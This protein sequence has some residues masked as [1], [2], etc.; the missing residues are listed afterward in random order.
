M[1]LGFFYKEFLFVSR[2]IL[3]QLVRHMMPFCR[4]I[5]IATD[6]GANMRTMRRERATKRS[7]K[8]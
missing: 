8:R 2:M 1:V 5:R 3:K 7:V 4:I 6:I